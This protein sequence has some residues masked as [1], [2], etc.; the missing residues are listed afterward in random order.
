MQ[1]PNNEIKVMLIKMRW[2]SKENISNWLIKIKSWPREKF[3]LGKVAKPKSANF[4]YE[5]NLKKTGLN[6]HHCCKEE[7]LFLLY[8]LSSKDKNIH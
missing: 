4:V 5:G 7:N 2:N 1:Y 8:E 3:L 6:I